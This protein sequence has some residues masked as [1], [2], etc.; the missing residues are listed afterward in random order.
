MI[1]MRD[2]DRPYPHEGEEYKEINKD[3]IKSVDI[4]YHRNKL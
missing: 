1:P 2:K 4:K 3:K